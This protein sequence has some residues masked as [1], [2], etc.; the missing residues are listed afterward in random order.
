MESLVPVLSLQTQLGMECDRRAAARMSRDQLAIKIDDL[1]RAWYHQ[2]ALIDQLLGELRQ[3]QVK[4][5]LAGPPVPAKRKPE[6]RHVEWAREL[7]WPH[8][9]H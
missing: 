7:L 3:A 9:Q 1:I 8:H 5:A 6:Q 4:L 2:H